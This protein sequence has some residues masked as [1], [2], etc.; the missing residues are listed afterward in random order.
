MRYL[1]CVRYPTVLKYF[2][3]ILP[4]ALY[5]PT[6][7]ALLHAP[8]AHTISTDFGYSNGTLI[9]QETQWVRLTQCFKSPLLITG[10]R[11]LWFCSLW[12]PI[13]SLWS[14]HGLPMA[15]FWLLF[16]SLGL[17]L[18]VLIP[19]MF[20]SGYPL[21]SILDELP[22]GYPFGHEDRHLDFVS[23]GDGVFYLCTYSSLV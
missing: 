5:S 12:V 11:I 7:P 4:T 6:L 9:H 18:Q 3:N 17:N 15:S 13:E 8:P 20:S 1:R 21:V 22:F 19:Y 10:T 16:Y 14:P 2:R 23:D